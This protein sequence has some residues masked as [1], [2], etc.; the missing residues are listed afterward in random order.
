V[1]VENFYK[2]Y[3]HEAGFS[4]HNGQHKEED[5]EIVTKYFYCSREC[6]RVNNG[7]NVIDQLEKRGKK[8]KTHNV[9]ETRCGC[10]AHIYVM[11]KKLSIN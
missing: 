7:K 6:Y 11:A 4:V 10:E 8:R 2:D 9:M 5:E 3:A 1:D